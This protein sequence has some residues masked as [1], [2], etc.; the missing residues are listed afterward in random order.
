MDQLEN[1][2]YY[3]FL[4]INTIYNLETEEL[5]DKYSVKQLQQRDGTSTK[6]QV[7]IKEPATSDTILRILRMHE[8]KMATDFL[9]SEF[10]RRNVHT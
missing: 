5:I 4:A 7:S 10:E 9:R 1:S 3:A 2:Q 8:T 6:K